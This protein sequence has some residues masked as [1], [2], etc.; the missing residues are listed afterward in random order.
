MTLLTTAR[1]KDPIDVIGYC[2]M[3][4]HFHLVLYPRTDTALS[5]YM[6]RVTGSY[7]CNYR[8]RTQTL[9]YGHVFKAPFWS[10]P[11]TSM[12]HFVATL[13]Y[14]EANPMRAGLVAKAQ[15]WPWSSLKA[16]GDDTLSELL[17]P[18]PIALPSYWDELVNL[19]Q[20][21]EVLERLREALEPPIGR[22]KKK[23]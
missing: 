23:R 18:L 15:D 8:R 5:A 14:V 10:R 1:E 11:I 9:G 16:R 22:P 21:A 17:S 20:H 19:P 3:P 7:A 12:E 6:K 13:R 4:N 2:G